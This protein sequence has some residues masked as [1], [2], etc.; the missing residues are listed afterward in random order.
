ME[1]RRFERLVVGGTAALVCISLAASVAS[2]GV[3]L[4]EVI[5]QLAIVAVMF[6]A[7]HWGRRAGTYAALAACLLY[8]ALR[9]PMIATGLTPQAFLLMVTRFAGY[10]L[11]GI[12]GGEVFGRVKYLFVG[13][14]GTS[15]IDDWS[16]VYNQ[17]YASHAIEQAIARHQRYGEPFSLVV[18]VLDPTL[19][20]TQRPQKLRG[21]VR[22][23]ASFIRDD[24]RMVDDVARLNDGRFAVLLPHTPGSAAPIVAERLKEGVAKTL[25]V[26]P[27]LVVTA[28]YG[29]DTHTA[30][31]G[32]FAA[33]LAE[34]SEGPAD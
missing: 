16:R 1:Y 7:V 34:P 18:V 29:A 6:A 9:L 2:G 23:V 14:D 25:G 12:V 8:L 4:A 17:A 3:D 20:G 30:A 21:L 26:K 5:G 28:C 22:T 24:V 10:C 33:E 19:T 11:V 27:D 32:A 15:V 31:L 13:S